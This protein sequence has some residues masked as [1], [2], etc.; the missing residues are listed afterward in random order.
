[1]KPKNK[2]ILIIRDGWGY[3]TKNPK[4]TGNAQVLARMP[5]TNYYE[6]NYP[7]TLLNAHGNAVGLPA[8]TQG[9]SEVGHY[10]IGAGRIIWQEFEKINRSIASSSKNSKSSKESFFKNKTLLNAMHHVKKFKS[11]LHLMGLFSDEGV[12]GTTE[13]LYAL[14]KMAKQQ[15]VKNVYVHCFLDGRDVPEK[16]A[17]TY[18]NEFKKRTK[19]LGVDKTVKIA[20]I[21]GRYYAMDRD[22]NW[23]RTQMAYELLVYGKGFIEDDTLTA[24]K[25]AYKYGAQSDYYVKPMKMRGTPNISDKDAVIFWNFRTDRARQ[26]TYAF[27][28]EKFEEHKGRFKVKKLKNLNYVCMTNYDRNMKLNCAFPETYVKNNLGS[29]LAKHKL[30]QLRIAETEKYAHVTFFFN[31]QIEKVNKGE[32]R[33]LIP[34]PKCPSYA[35]KPEMSAYGITSKLLEKI[36]SDKFDFI[37]VNF[38]NGDLVGHSGNLKATIKCCEVVDE[39]VGKIVK[40]AIDKNYVIMLTADH[41]NCEEMFYPNGEPKPSHTLNPVQFMLIC[42]DNALL[43]GNK[44]NRLRNITLKKGKGLANIAPTILQLIGIKKDKEM[45]ESLIL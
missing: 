33:V 43:N 31:S 37:L 35:Q 5:N 25:K 7:F 38:A 16:S 44:R 26:L 11:K 9:G 19:A 20:S 15:K 39:C 17:A 8:N 30:K 45:E 24:M 13:H 34:S 23:D 41:G 36:K 3:S 27:A 1:M 22:N 12:H 18:F 10:T 21:I 6:K 29:I 2:I 14:L 32:E 42:G 28:N 40:A 4:K